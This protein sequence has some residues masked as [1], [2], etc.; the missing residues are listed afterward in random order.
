MSITIELFLLSG[1]NLTHCFGSL[2]IYVEIIKINIDYYSQ[3]IIR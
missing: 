1:F 2:I 3:E